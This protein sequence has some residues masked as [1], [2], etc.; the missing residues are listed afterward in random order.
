E[1]VRRRDASASRTDTS[2]RRI[3]LDVAAHIAGFGGA[4][5]IYQLMFED[6]RR[7]FADTLR[8][9]ADH[10]IGLDTRWLTVEWH[11]T[12]IRSYEHTPRVTGFTTGG[13]IA[14][15]PLGPAAHAVFVGGRIPARWGVVSPWIELAALASDSYSLDDRIARTSD[16]PAELRFRIGARAAVPLGPD[17]ELDPEIAIEAVEREAFVPGAQRRNTV[18]RA[19]LVWR[20]GIQLPPGRSR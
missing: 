18:L 14:G 7:Q 2:N 11:R 17:L 20:P 3:G 12:G 15:D 9:D 5:I 1:H 8:Y 6:V 4:R 19:V 10:A 16:R 13:R